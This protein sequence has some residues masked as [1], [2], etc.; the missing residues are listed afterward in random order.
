M[1]LYNL[2]VIFII[3]LNH[4]DSYHTKNVFNIRKNDIKKVSMNKLLKSNDDDLLFYP[5]MDIN[6]EQDI[7]SSVQFKPKKLHNHS[8]VNSLY[9][10][11]PSSFNTSKDSL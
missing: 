7:L 3:V 9:L 11:L 8:Y 1:Y 4:T 10:L 5:N 2:L 6:I